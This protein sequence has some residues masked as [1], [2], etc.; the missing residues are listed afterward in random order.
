MRPERP[1]ASGL[2]RGASGAGLLRAAGYDEAA[3]A[4]PMIAIVSA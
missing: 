4:R 3:L 2:R 1:R